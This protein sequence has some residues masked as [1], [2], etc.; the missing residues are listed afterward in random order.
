MNGE[1]KE[2][3]AAVAGVKAQVKAEGQAIRRELDQ[4]RA[5]MD[6]MEGRVDE[7]ST[8]FAGL[9]EAVKGI[10][11]EAGKAGGLVAGAFVAAVEAVKFWWFKGTGQ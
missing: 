5:R 1:T 6:R 3:L 9:E 10:R 7:V 2:I 8:G 4:G 11:R